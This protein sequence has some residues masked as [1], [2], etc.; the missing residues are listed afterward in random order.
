M[1]RTLLIVLGLVLLLMA[2]GVLLTMQGG[3]FHLGLPGLGKPQ[4]APAPAPSSP[5]PPAESAAP[6]QAAAPSAQAPAASA[7]E[8]APP[9]PPEPPRPHRRHR[10]AH[11]H[12]DRYSDAYI[13]DHGDPTDDRT[14]KACDRKDW[15]ATIRANR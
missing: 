10:A 5:A 3:G 6:A 9:A 8:S 12:V 11:R 7:A 15:A 2:A 13:C 4:A 14:I 1:K